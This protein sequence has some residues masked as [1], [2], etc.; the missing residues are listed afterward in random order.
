MIW[1]TLAALS[2]RL[3]LRLDPLRPDPTRL[4]GLGDIRAIGSGKHTAR[5]NVLRTGEKTSARRHAAARRP[6]RERLRFHGWRFR[7]RG[8]FAAALGAY[9]RALLSGV[10]EIKGG[11]GVRDVFRRARR[12]VHWRRWVV[13][14]LVWLASRSLTRYSSLSG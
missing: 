3:L 11:K 2:D 12:A 9:H 8:R 7:P 6:S 10:A 13:T 14:A 4:A 1:G 5:P